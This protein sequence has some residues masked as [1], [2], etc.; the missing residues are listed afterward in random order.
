MKQNEN[1]IDKKATELVTFKEKIRNKTMQNFRVIRINGLFF[2]LNQAPYSC[3]GST[4]FG[5]SGGEGFSC[6]SCSSAIL[7]EIFF[8]KFFYNFVCASPHSELTGVIS[9]I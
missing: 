4:R 2:P 3:S 9:P 1:I 7:N 5:S 8:K 6:G